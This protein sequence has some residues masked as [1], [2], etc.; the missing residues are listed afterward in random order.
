MTLG[1]EHTRKLAIKEK[2]DKLD[3]IN[4]RNLILLEGQN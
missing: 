4:T 2:I 3:F 1:K